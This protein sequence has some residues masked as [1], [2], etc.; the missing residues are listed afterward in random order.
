MCDFSFEHPDQLRSHLKIHLDKI[1]YLQHQPIPVSVPAHKQTNYFECY[2][3]K[4]RLRAFRDVKKHLKLHVAARDNKCVICEENFT[5]NE[6]DW[7]L[8]YSEKIILCEYCN[9]T[10]GSTSKLI[11]HLE[12][13]HDD[14]TI[15]QCRK[16]PRFFGTSQLRLWHERQHKDQV[17]AFI[18]ELCSK[19]FTERNSLKNHSK[20]HETQQSR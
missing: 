14:R 19:R 3:C 2:I 10:F 9:N 12:N 7:H 5:L 16:C 8:C 4:I 18:C 6:I 15:Y 11:Q 13:V 20:T 17:K 1:V